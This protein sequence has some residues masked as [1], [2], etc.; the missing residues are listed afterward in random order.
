MPLKVSDIASLMDGIAPQRLAEAW[1]N[2]GLLM[3]RADRTVI[4]V[5][6]ALD[7]SPEVV[8]EAVT[9]GA[10]ML[11]THHPLFIRPLKRL[12]LASPLG[13]TIETALKSDLAIFSAHTNLDRARGGVNETLALKLGITNCQPL[14]PD[15]GDPDDFGLGFTGDLP[16]AFKLSELCRFVAKSLGSAQVRSAGDND[17]LVSRVAACSGGGRSLVGAFLASGAEV[18]ITGDLGY[19]DAKEVAD[20]GKALIDA[21]HFATEHIVVEALAKKLA[22]AL[23]SNGVE[24]FV[25]LSEKDPFQQINY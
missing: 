6:L 1:D 22:P 4:K 2:V 9:A 16:G 15:K 21:G 3:G 14:E 5:C 17:M 12:D 23:E 19:H 25:C 20:N 8:K 10:Q 7:A 11:I 18:F 13:Y 24:I